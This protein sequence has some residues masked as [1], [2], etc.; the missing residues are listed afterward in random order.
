MNFKLKYNHITLK[1]IKKENIISD[2]DFLSNW[3][4]NSIF[5]KESIEKSILKSGD[6]FKFEIDFM[7]KVCEIIRLLKIIY[8]IP[9]KRKD[10]YTHFNDNV[11]QLKSFKNEY[12]HVLKSLPYI[13]K[14]TDTVYVDYEGIR[15]INQNSLNIPVDGQIT[16]NQQNS[17]NVIYKHNVKVFLKNI[18]LIQQ[19]IC[20]DV[21]NIMIDYIKHVLIV[22]QS[23]NI[24]N[25]VCLF[26]YCKN[27]IREILRNKKNVQN[28]NSNVILFDKEESIFSEYYY[29]NINLSLDMS[30]K[31]NIELFNTTYEDV[32]KMV[33]Y[34]YNAIVFNINQFITD[35]NFY[36][37][38]FKY[39]I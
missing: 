29:K 10:L 16:M 9:I 7:K 8:I 22:S 37:S 35:Y 34:K 26:W 12:N 6:L 11:Y 30:L 14:Y 39:L 27:D 28:F 24:P 32:L 2:I 19:Y 18:N 13:V 36:K 4:F 3:I 23:F 15:E 20:L 21:K 25:K 5:K 1:K 31:Y 17:M 38:E 33:K